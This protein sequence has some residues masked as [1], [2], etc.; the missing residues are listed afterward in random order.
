MRN[1]E[2]HDR[3]LTLPRGSHAPAASANAARTKALAVRLPA[4]VPKVPQV[5]VVPVVPVFPAI[6]PR[7]ARR[8]RT[9][10]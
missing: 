7:Y 5:P 9:R 4:R 2:Y 6:G 10:W 1:S 8:P 3:V